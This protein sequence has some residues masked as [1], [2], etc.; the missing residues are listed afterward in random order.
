[1]QIFSLSLQ[2]KPNNT[3]MDKKEE[4]SKGLTLKA[5]NKSSVWDLQENDIF[6]M[7]EAAEKDADL[8]DNMRHYIDVIKSA[9]EM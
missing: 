9:F 2:Q 7:W 6:R 5:L 3:N 1:M 8:K 4:N